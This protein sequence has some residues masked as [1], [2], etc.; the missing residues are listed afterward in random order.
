MA[1]AVHEKTFS[2]AGATQRD[3]HEFEP[4]IDGPALAKAMLDKYHTRFAC[5]EEMLYLT[6]IAASRDDRTTING[7]ECLRQYWRAHPDAPPVSE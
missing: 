1:I 5:I 4:A 7:L 6:I 3:Y 2:Q